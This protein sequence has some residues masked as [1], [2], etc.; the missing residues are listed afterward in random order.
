MQLN[1]DVGSIVDDDALETEMGG[2]IS[3]ED[4]R[5]H[6]NAAAISAP[7]VVAPSEAPAALPAAARSATGAADGAP[8]SWGGPAGKGVVVMHSGN[9]MWLKKKKAIMGLLRM[10]PLMNTSTSHESETLDSYDVFP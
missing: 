10:E 6:H 3:S 7:H 9:M 4:D 2:D 1:N 5:I 8:E